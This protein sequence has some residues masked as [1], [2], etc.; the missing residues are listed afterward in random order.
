MTWN[1]ASP[2]GSLSVRDNRTLMNQNTTYIETTLGNTPS[3]QAYATSQKDH[4]F[5]LA[6]SNLNGHHRF[7]KMPAFT[8]GGTP[9]D[10]GNPL[11]TGI[12]GIFY[13]KSDGLS[14]PRVT[15]Y[16]RNANYIY[17]VFPIVLTGTINITSLT[18]YITINSVPD[19][20]YGDIFMYNADNDTTSFSG[21]N[22]FFKS[23]NG[24]LNAWATM[25]GAQGTGR[26]TASAALRFGNGS[27]SDGLNIRVRL[28]EGGAGDW[29]YVITYRRIP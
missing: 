24:T 19:G 3:D 4:F 11:G 6:G 22:G 15:G 25:Y 29:N 5:A 7:I 12:D 27:E 14:T 21:Q 10:P 23:R 20:V 26:N 8:V 28:N 9:S 16:F 1:S 2:S 18:N 13:F 17:Q